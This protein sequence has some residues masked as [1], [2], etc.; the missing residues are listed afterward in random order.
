[1]PE[2]TRVTRSYREGRDGYD[3]DDGSVIS[4]SRA[5]DSSY[6]SV[7]RYRVTPSRSEE[8]EIDRRSTRLDAPR[9]E[10]IEID[11]RERFVEPE[12]PR[13]SV[14][15][16][17]RSTV[18][19]R[20][21]E[22]EP[23][24]EPERE[25]EKERTRTVVY[26]RDRREPERSSWDRGPARPWE[27]ERDVR[28]T[29]LVRVEKR[30]AER[31]DE[32]YELERYQRET[33][34]YD[35][36]EPPPQ[37]I[38]IRQRAPEP[39]QIIVQEAPAPPPIVLPAREEQVQIVREEVTKEVAK[40]AE[41]RRTEDEYYYRKDVREVGPSRRN[42]E[43]LAITKYDRRD[44]RPRDSVS[45]RSYSEGEEYVIKKKRIVRE[46]SRSGSVHH[47]RHLAEGALAGAGAA[48]ILA[49]HRKKT[50]EGGGHG[51][52]NMVGGA[53]LGA[54]G[55][56]VLTRARSRYR[57]YDRSRS[58]SRSSSRHSHRR[59]K[60]ALGLAAAGLA[61][62]AA[63]KYVSNRKAD[64]EEYGRG[65][66]RTRSVSRRRGS[67]YDYDSYD[68]E[69]A[70]SRSR[71]KHANPKHR[72]ASIAKAG[73]ATAAVAGVVE[74]FRNKSRKRGGSRSKSRI[75]TGAEIAGAGLAGA[76][77]AGLYENRKAK[78]DREV[79][80]ED[81]RRSRRRSRSRARSI[82]TYSELGVDPELGMVQYG[83]EPVYSHQQ[84]ATYQRGY[85]DPAAAYGA[86]RSRSRRRHSSSSRSRRRSRSRSRSVAKVA[87]GTAAAAIG[88]NKYKKRKDKKETERE[89]ERRR[90]EEEA[91]PGNYY[92]RDYQ[93]DY[94]PSPPHA[95]GGSYYPQSNAFP[96]PPPQPGFTQ[97]TTTST[98]HVNHDGIPPYNPANY[99]HDA[100]YSG[101]HGDTGHYGDNV[102]ANYNSHDHH[103]PAAA[104]TVAM[105]YFPAPPVAPF[106]DQL[107]RDPFAD[108]GGLNPPYSP[109]S[110]SPLSTPPR[111]R[112]PSPFRPSNP[113]ASKSVV[114]APLSPESS[115]R[116]AYIHE[117]ASSDTHNHSVSHPDQS[118]PSS[119]SGS[120]TA[121][122]RTSQPQVRTRTRDRE[123]LSPSDHK[124]TRRRRRRNSDATSDRPTQESKHRR[125]HS[126]KHHSRSPSPS[127]SSSEVE[128]LPDRFDRDGR[129]LDKYGNSYRS[130]P[131]DGSLAGL[132]GNL[133]QGG[134]Q[135]MV[136]KLVGGF[137][138]VMEGRKSWKDLLRG[139]V[140]E[141]EERGS[142]RKRD[143]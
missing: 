56:E 132:V 52:R 107:T 36:P 98:T 114:F 95:S 70:R 121:V 1:M 99:D 30:T 105:P 136:E 13:S 37:P 140:E 128:V 113:N 110:A 2:V 66:S 82:G 80:T 116:L 134:Q 91:P 130:K 125:R 7:Q 19:E 90:Y 76:A 27:A 31:R 133:G 48:A 135:E 43:E 129:P 51:K 78:D 96:P 40:P 12:R 22:R 139:V 58:R 54:I 38:I 123:D 47:R 65:R 10:R 59:I 32:P 141:G 20:Y 42:D 25:H 61:A 83:T 29:D 89:R 112:N 75:R 74:H 101:H 92:A 69:R 62:A 127:W 131:K 46:R 108:A 53:A 34:Y 84:T 15:I 21:I 85:G 3:S 88:I 117:N 106:D 104:G 79:E 77:V 118:P 143:R 60:T 23:L 8:I 45:D 103:H 120:E 68:D 137:G 126:N 16:R 115:R 86:T 102:S 35:R 100:P 109:V 44:V 63:T 4:R 14:D 6:R 18:V 67:G 41:P 142:R 72:A 55:A 33:E 73:A 57:E 138:E 122:D 28:E 93:D 49:N 11:R 17:P 111:T 5:G 81:D 94:S 26:E 124:R 24:Y 64:R 50:G 87:A 9:V 119:P 97:Y 71:S 39:Q